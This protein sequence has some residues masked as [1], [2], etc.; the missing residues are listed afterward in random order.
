M[1]T[2]VA[3]CVTFAASTVLDNVLDVSLG[4]QLML[5]FL[6]GG[7]TLLVQ[8]LAEF[9]QSVREFE[10]LQR[11]TLSELDTL[12]ARSLARVNEATE[13]HEQI[14]ASEL[15]AVALKTVIHGAGRFSGGATPLT[16]R[17]ANSEI[18]RLAA[19]LRSL[20]GG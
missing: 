12:I 11:Q 7:V 6:T 17:L 4:D 15:D 20:A 19:T 10:A 9:E 14:S 5:A 3:G 13:L 2:A 1:W 18:D 16:R 8:Y